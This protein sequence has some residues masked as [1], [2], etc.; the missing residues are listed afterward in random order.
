MLETRVRDSPCSSLLLRWSSGRV[1]ASVPSSSRATRIGSATVCESSPF[2]PFTVTV[3]PSIVTSTPD[4]TVI[5]S[6]PMRDIAV[7]LLPRFPSPDEGEDF[8]ADALVLGLLVGQQPLRGRDD[9]DPQTAEHL[10]Q[11]GRLRVYAKAGLADPAKPGDRALTA[12][13]ELQVD[14]QGPAHRTLLGLLDLVGRDVALLL[15]DVGDAGLDLAVRHRGRLVVRLV[16]VTQTGQHV[17][18]RVGHRHG[19]GPLSRRGFAAWCGDLRRLGQSVSSG[20]LSGCWLCRL[21]SWTTSW[22]WSRPAARRG[23]PCP[24]GRSGTGRTC[25]RPTSAGRSAGS[26]CRRARRTSACAPA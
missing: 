22:T 6:L 24:A 20:C 5:G 13:A 18:D 8:P 9:R 1:T 15:E 16:G 19:L 26:G 12:R 17:C 14:D 11:A 10:G 3:W 21:E 25:G 23:A 7:V 4:G 2:G